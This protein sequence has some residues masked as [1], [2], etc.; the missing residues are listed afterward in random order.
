MPVCRHNSVATV[1]VG[2]SAGKCA[3]EVEFLGVYVSKRA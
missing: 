3:E 1:A 2:K